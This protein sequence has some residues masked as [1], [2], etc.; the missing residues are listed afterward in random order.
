MQKFSALGERGR[1][2]DLSHYYWVWGRKLTLTNWRYKADMKHPAPD[3]RPGALRKPL[4]GNQSTKGQPKMV[5]EFERQRITQPPAEWQAAAVDAPGETVYR[6]TLFY[7]GFYG[8]PEGRARAPE[9][10]LAP[11]PV[12]SAQEPFELM[13]SDS[14]GND[15]TLYLVDS[16]F[17]QRIRHFSLV[18]G[19]KSSRASRTPGKPH[20]QPLSFIFGTEDWTH[21]YSTTKV[22]HIPSQAFSFSFFKILR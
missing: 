17:H 9:K 14:V 8:Q 16:I 2:K 13:G 5:A 10:N 15:Q 21:G 12:L 6:K 22:Y 18:C 4:L 1:T 20:P 3:R 7:A 11:S 19:V